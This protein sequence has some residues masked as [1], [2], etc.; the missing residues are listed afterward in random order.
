[1]PN[2]YSHAHKA[3]QAAGL[4]PKKDNNSMTIEGDNVVDET[5]TRPVV[6]PKQSPQLPSDD[7]SL[8]WRTEQ[9]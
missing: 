4:A 3:R 1:M 8:R 5:G 9:T 6:P 7:S 2:Q